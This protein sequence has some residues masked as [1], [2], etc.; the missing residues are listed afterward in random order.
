M[1]KNPAA[2]I[3]DVLQVQETI[4]PVLKPQQCLDQIEKKHKEGLSLE[5]Q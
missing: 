2:H 5:A 1:Y 3:L 4:I